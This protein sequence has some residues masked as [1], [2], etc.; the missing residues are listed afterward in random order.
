MSDR[1]TLIERPWDVML[2]DRALKYGPEV[3]LRAE[4]GPRLVA[5]LETS[6]RCEVQRRG[7]LPFVSF[8]FASRDHL[9]AARR[10]P[11]PP[12][13]GSHRHTIEAKLRVRDV[14]C[15]LTMSDAPVRPG[16]ADDNLMG[17]R[18][19]AH[20]EWQVH[21]F[22]ELCDHSKHAWPDAVRCVW[23][24]AY[25]IWHAPG[26]SDARMALVAKLAQESE[27]TRVLR[28]VA[29]APRRILERVRV[30]TP[31]SRIQELDAH[32]IRNYVRRP[33]RTAV[34][35]A[36]PRQRLL[37]VLRRET[38][39]TLENRVASWTL[40]RIEQRARTYVRQN[41]HFLAAKSARVISV[42]GFGIMAADL[43]RREDLASADAQGLH[44]PVQ[45][46]YTL[47]MDAR[48]RVIYRTYQRL[49]REQMVLDDA[50]SWQQALWADSIRQLTYS[51]I[52]DRLAARYGTSLYCRREP[53]RG[54]WT[55][56]PLAPGPY[57][58]QSG[59]MQVIDAADAISD[60][61]SW[62]Q[63]GLPFA[64]TLGMTGSDFALWWPDKRCLLVVWAV[65]RTGTSAAWNEE[66]IGA[67]RALDHF[68]ST[69]RASSGSSCDVRGL[70]LAACTS[71]DA[72]VA[73]GP[74]A[75]FVQGVPRLWRQVWCWQ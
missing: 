54:T 18:L 64:A 34:E 21:S 41:A 36:G 58:S 57:V 33:G 37:G 11:L 69:L 17:R 46:N 39:R 5:P 32:C 70:L 15:L 68:A 72:G 27:L 48:Y 19:D 50:W 60:P 10:I 14:E 56:T 12:Q 71:T 13:E 62:L 61:D 67:C 52:A 59:E 66:L 28:S 16:P 73:D 40:E 42:R 44:H 1:A 43:A 38:S 29:C 22:E 6:V 65:V 4:C 31:V 8:P 49:V 74:H 51:F 24:D 3:A 26:R 20:C 9:F 35:K 2:S 23:R 53:D 63:S 47:Q 25:D 30:E 45:P 75:R 7:D 55:L